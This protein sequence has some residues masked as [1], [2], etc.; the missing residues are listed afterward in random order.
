[1]S[2]NKISDTP[3]DLELD[4]EFEDMSDNKSGDVVI[5][6]EYEDDDS[7]EYVEDEADEAFDRAEKKKNSFSVIRTLILIIAGAVFCYSAYMLCQIFLEYKKGTDTYHQIENTVLNEDS[8]ISVSLES[9]EVEIPFTYDHQTLLSINPD[10]LGYIYLPAID[11]RLPLVQTTDNDYYLEHT[12][13]RVYNKGGCLF[14]DY[15]CSDGLSSKNVVIHGHNMKNGSMFG[16]LQRY[17]SSGFTLSE[18][19]DLIYIYTGDILKQYRIFSV[20]VSDP[21]NMDVYRYQISTESALQ[22]YAATVKALSLFNTG[23]DVSNAS[24]VLTLSTCTN[25][26]KQRVVV[27]AVYVSEAKLDATE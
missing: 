13:N 14:E 5:N 1:M 6:D 15:R 11:I 2:S 9:G 25:D 10:G 3:E 22:E 27:H 23:V 7:F 12:F 24:Q 19:N 18:G 21:V 16:K 17:K 8:T 4:L 26:S 20:H